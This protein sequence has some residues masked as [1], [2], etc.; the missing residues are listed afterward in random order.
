VTLSPNIQMV[1]LTSSVQSIYQCQMT[2]HS[3][4]SLVKSPS[5]DIP[6]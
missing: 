5:A 2:N 3:L 1:L 4:S 6:L